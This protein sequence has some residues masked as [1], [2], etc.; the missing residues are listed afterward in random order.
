VRL[1]G[2]QE[3]VVPLNIGP[4]VGV[5]L[6]VKTLATLWDGTAS[7]PTPLRRRLT[8]ITRWQRA[9]ARTRKG[10]PNRCKGGLRL[11]RLHRRVAQ[12]RANTVQHLTSRLANTKS[13]VVM[14]DRNVA[15]MLHNQHL[16]HALGAGGFAEFRRHRTSKAAG[17]GCQVVVVSRWE[18]SSK[19]CSG[20]G[21]VHDD[22]ALS[23][24]VFVCRN[25]ARPNCGLVLDRDLNAALHLA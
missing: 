13:V 25:P 8:K 19:T 22:L 3:Q 1:P 4:A 24:R 16:A 15:G 2:E 14:E 12:Q 10:S 21:W 5:D 6:G 20:G 17:Y 7:P 23:D 11:A 9:V 18:P